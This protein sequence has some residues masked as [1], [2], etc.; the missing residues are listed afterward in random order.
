MFLFQI[1]CEKITEHLP[2]T[3]FSKYYNNYQISIRTSKVN[4]IIL[5]QMDTEISK[6]DKEDELIQLRLEI[7]LLEKKILLFFE[8]LGP[9][10]EKEKFLRDIDNITTKLN[11]KFHKM[12]LILID[13]EKDENIYLNFRLIHDRNLLQFINVFKEKINELNKRQEL[14]LQINSTLAED[15]CKFQKINNDWTFFIDSIME[16]REIIFQ[17][18]EK[19]RLFYDCRQL[20]GR[21]VSQLSVISATM[22]NLRDINN[23]INL[24]R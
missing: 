16:A 2:D 17:K 9:I 14:F 18:E 22:L 23:N 5:N 7:K 20:M 10:F 6:L 3:E 11:D 21:L 24:R 8:K 13:A 12:L 19:L 15:C 1:E 4:L